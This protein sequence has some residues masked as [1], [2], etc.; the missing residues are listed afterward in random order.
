MVEKIDDSPAVW[1]ATLPLEKKSAVC[2][3]I[4]VMAEIKNVNFSDLE[5]LHDYIDGDSLNSVLG[6]KH[7][8]VEF[9]YEDCIVRATGDGRVLIT[10]FVL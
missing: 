6:N 2:G 3:I 10:E 8:S 9:C 4:E 7:L 5:C 1:K